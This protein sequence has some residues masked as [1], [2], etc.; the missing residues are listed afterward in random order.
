MKI[1]SFILFFFLSLKAFSQGIIVDTTSLSIPQLVHTVLM[2][3][4]CSNE[5]NFVNSSK[6]GIGKF[7]N[8]N[9]LFPFPNGIIIRNGIAKYT[10]GK[11]TGLNLSSQLNNS[12]DPDLQVISNSSL[13]TGAITDVG[14]I[15][16]DFTPISSSF[17]F[18]FVFA[19][20]E[21]GQYQCGFSDVF[22]FILTD[23]TTNI[24]TNLAVIPSTSTPVSVKTIR[25]SAYNNSCTSSNSG[26]F[27]RY[28]V[29]NPATSAINMKGETVLLTASSPVIPNRTYRIKLAIGDYFDGSYDSAVFIK[30]G[31]FTTYT[32]LGPDK[33][34]CQGEN[35][36]LSSG[37]LPPYSVSWTLNG[38]AIAGENGT[39]L[40]VNQPGTYGVIGTLANTGC[41]ITDEIVISN[42][43]ISSLNN[44]SVC[45]SGAAT[46]QYDLTQNNL[47][48]LGLNPNDYSILYF[49]SLAAANANTPQIPINQLTSYTSAG[50]QT[51]YVKVMHLTNGNYICNNLLPFDLLVTLPFSALSPNNLPLCADAAG[52]TTT[53]L[54]GQN[55]LVLNGQP[56]ANFTISYFISQTDAQNNTNPILTPT[57]FITTLAQSPQT[58][59]VRMNSNTN[60][61]CF[62]VTSF[63]ITVFPKPLVDT[64]PNVI[65]CHS[66]FLPVITNGNYFTGSNGTGTMLNAGD[67]ILIPGTYYIFNGPDAQGCKNESKFTVTL[68]DQLVFPLTGCGIYTIPS[69]GIGNF[70]TGPGGTGTQLVGGTKLNSSQTI[71]YY[72]VIKGLVCRDEVINITVFVLPAVATLPNVTTCN[73]Y[74]LP[75]IVDGSF[76][77]S[78]GGKGTRLFA[79]NTINTTQTVYI[80][81]NDGRCS[82]ETSFTINII[83]TAI[84]TTVI[85]CGSFTLPAITIGN[86]YTQPMGAGTVIPAGTSITTSQIVYYYAPTTT[87]PNC[88]DLLNY[89]ITILP[90]PSVDAPSNRLECENYILPALTNGSYFSSTGGMGPLNAG[91]IISQNKTIYVHATSNLGCT[92][93]NSFTITIRQKPVVDIFT[94]VFTCS[95]YSL[96]SLKNGV[97][98]S[99]PNGP[100]GSGS[101]IPV[102]TII[103]SSQRIYIYNAW[104]D[105]LSCSN[106]SF[107]NVDYSAVDVGAFADVNACDRYLLPALTVIGAGYYSQPNGVNPIPVGTV[108]TTSQRIYVYKKSGTRL[109]CSDQADFMVN[110]ANTPVLPNYPNV[111]SCGNSILG[112]LPVGA[113]YF[114]GPNASATAYAVGQSITT[115]QPIYVYAAAATNATCFNQK[116]FTIL[117]YP[118][119]NLVIN[120]GVICVDNVTG[121]LIQSCVLSSGLNPTIYTVNWYLNGVLMG[122]GPN[123]NAVKEGTYDVVIVKNTPNIGPDCGYNP[124]T[125]TVIKSSAPNATLVVSGTFDEVINISVNL[126]SGLG[127]YEFQMDNGSFQTD[128][129]FYDVTSGV[130]TINIKDT[131]GNCSRISLIAHIIKYP[132][133][134]TPNGDSY[135]DT[136]N[137]VD[138]AFQPD[139][140]I[141][142]Y[143][144]YGKFIKELKT[145]GPGWDGNLNGNPLPSSDYWFQVFY[146]YNNSPQEFKSH[147]SLKR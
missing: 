80:Y 6:R 39:T 127:T 89:T 62:D 30:G 124:T 47:A 131:K 106:E 95:D 113:N 14:F 52:S 112:A 81:S 18:D 134:F 19:S 105:F 90:L 119:K 22:A 145:N 83:N 142:I 130:H 76:Y 32:D 107:F 20:N 68:V 55:N 98:Y 135:H 94:D 144:R 45:N 75:S 16:F 85:K 108:I 17:S 74:T 100:N 91:A 2:P 136:W 126:T 66:Y 129:I 103:N 73:S 60:S 38:N 59:W 110:I 137:I 86:Y 123:Y 132:N 26:L 128:P 40:T 70:Y 28:N 72:A 115:S 49:P 104:P 121:A 146:Q 13:Q 125:V 27:A 54:T 88:T 4:S 99:A 12:G 23:L 33:I 92:N 93:Q 64:L 97:Y 53:N 79:G 67:E 42:L 29:A 143:D 141:Y 138:L 25:D 1:K 101:L 57:A 41:Q 48:T 96:P 109:T 56:S 111:S 61:G 133:Y 71:Y 78:S 5:T 43:S 82:N 34:I 3:N 63:T 15:Q 7:T 51:I 9:P 24:K 11:Y 117:I 139:A 46:Y 31:S 118:L 84:Y 116:T 120:D 58:V 36:I 87:T 21:Y 122:T 37:L 77:T 114:S 140:Y 69:P 8:S 102:G 65:E 44:L 50:G 10:E 147:F 35:V